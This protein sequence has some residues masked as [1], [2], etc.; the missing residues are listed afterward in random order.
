MSLESRMTHD[1]GFNDNGGL[2]NPLKNSG[3]DQTVSAQD[4]E[5]DMDI[6]N[7]YDLFNDPI[8]SPTPD[9][10]G[11]IIQP[12]NTKPVQYGSS[13][14]LPFNRYLHPPRPVQ[15]ATRPEPIRLLNS[16]APPEQRQTTPE[17]SQ[18]SPAAAATHKIKAAEVPKRPVNTY[19]GNDPLKRL[20]QNKKL[21]ALLA[22]KKMP[23]PRK[24]PD[25]MV[26]K[27]AGRRE[28]R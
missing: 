4:D 17:E 18:A 23:G 13:Y 10:P 9:S 11:T 6:D 20:V 3:Q 26:L 5:A 22:D 24:K 12:L 25:R 8:L 16:F 14:H 2:V 28:F 7:F 19:R 27:C 21:R 1:E 15:P